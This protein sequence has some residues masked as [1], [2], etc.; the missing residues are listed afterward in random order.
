MVVPPV[1]ALRPSFGAPIPIGAGGNCAQCPFGAP[2]GIPVGHH[3]HPCHALRTVLSRGGV[4][5][6]HH[7]VGEPGT[8]G[9]GVGTRVFEGA[10]A[11]RRR[12]T[13]IDRAAGCDIENC[14]STLGYMTTV[15][16]EATIS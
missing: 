9:D 3:D 8:P 14:C 10:H 7:M 16:S 11:G 13:N 5:Q 6:V 12:L 2:A 4:Q 15:E 1:F